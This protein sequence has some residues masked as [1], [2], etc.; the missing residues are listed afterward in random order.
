MSGSFEIWQMLPPR[1]RRTWRRLPPGLQLRG[2]RL[3]RLHTQLRRA[4]LPFIFNYF[5][6]GVHWIL[7]RLGLPVSHYL[8]DFFGACP[9]ADAPAIMRLVTLV[10]KSL[11]GQVSR[12]KCLWGHSVEVLGVTFD[13]VAGLAWLSE[14]K[15]TRLKDGVRTLA[16]SAPAA[17]ETVKSLAGLLIFVS[18]VCR[19]GRA[20]MRGIFDWLR[21]SDR[22]RVCAGSPLSGPALEDVTWW[23][24]VLTDWQGKSVV[25][26]RPLQSEVWTD[27][28]STAGIGGHLGPQHLPVAVFSLPAP[29]VGQDIMTLEAEALRTALARWGSSL[30]R[31]RVTCKVDNQVLAAGITSG[32]CRHAPTQAVIRDIFALTLR[33]DIELV[34]EWVPSEEN[35]IADALS[36]FDAASLRSRCPYV[37]SL[38]DVDLPTV[39]RA[40]SPLHN[41]SSPPT[42]PVWIEPLDLSLHA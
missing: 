5:A 7:E 9:A 22:G 38:V 26:Q 8:D 11:G 20:F 13:T 14:D 32:R 35:Y 42:A 3:R 34:A 28:A 29:S 33:W 16:S 30:N 21:L 15:L 27:A 31:H 6:E 40:P 24:E 39:S 10:I 4:L 25:Q 1:R 17:V 18:R 23:D 19:P 2:R 41:P 12:S 36:R 37:L